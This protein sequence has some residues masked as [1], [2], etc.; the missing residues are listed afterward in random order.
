MRRTLLGCKLPF[1]RRR[2]GEILVEEQALD[3]QE[4]EE[5]L[6]EKK[7]SPQVRLGYIA[8]EKGMISPAQLM[9]ALGLQMKSI[10]E[11]SGR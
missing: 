6:E 9:K 4:L 8:L 5:I 7:R 1:E 11:H 2:L 3:P 10:Y